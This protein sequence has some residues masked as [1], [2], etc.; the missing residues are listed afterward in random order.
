MKT[1]EQRV[2]TNVAVIY[3]VR[4]FTG[5][6]AL[7]LYALVV[8]ILGIATFVSVSNVMTNFTHVAQGGVESIVTFVIA[9]ILGTT[10]AVQIALLLGVAAVL[11]LIV[12]A[13][14]SR[15][16]SLHTQTA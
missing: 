3:I 9:A 7:K 5:F 6:T 12:D 1:I 10:I 8:S 16:S 2:M 14:R 11:S 15:S 13:V 4:K